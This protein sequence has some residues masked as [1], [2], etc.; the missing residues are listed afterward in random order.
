MYDP[1]DPYAPYDYDPYYGGGPPP[2]PWGPMA[3]P[4]PRRPPQPPPLVG[5]DSP[6]FDYY[7]EPYGRSAP[8]GRPPGLVQMGP[9]PMPP[10][11]P[12]GPIGPPPPPLPSWGEPPAVER[13][14]VGLVGAGNRGPSSRV[15]H[16][17]DDD[18]VADGIVI[19]PK[20]SKWRAVSAKR[21]VREPE[22][23]REVYAARPAPYVDPAYP[24][25]FM[26]QGYG[27]PPMA[28]YVR[29]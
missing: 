4:G 15:V 1:Y 10:M 21:I 26:P 16:F 11:P 2:P 13:Q 14:F 3:G 22:I 25:F 20:K 5:I 6:P 9:P 7:P 19:K 23:R 18:L 28:A 12:I 27:P 24:G 8:P 17:D 29:R